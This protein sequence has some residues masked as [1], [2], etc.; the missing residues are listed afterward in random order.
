MD[1]V[2]QKLSDDFEVKLSIAG[3]KLILTV[4]FDG[5]DELLDQV[6][7]KLPS[8]LAPLVDLVKLEVDRI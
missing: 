5:A 6:K 3:G 4:E 1:V 2:D 8:W 7:A